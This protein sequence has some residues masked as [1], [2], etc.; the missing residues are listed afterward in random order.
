MVWLRVIRISE[1]AVRL[2]RTVG[3]TRRMWVNRAKKC[4][5]E[6]MS[7]EPIINIAAYRF[8]DLDELPDLRTELRDLCSR[9]SLR[10]TVLIATEGINLF[11]AGTRNSTDQFIAYLRNDP[12]FSRIAIK[13]SAS[14]Y[15]PFNRM[16]VKIKR[17][18]IPFGVPGIDPSK[19]GSP[20]L[21][22]RELKR[23]LDEGRHFTLLDVRNDFE[24]QVGTFQGAVPIGIDHFRDFPAAIQRL[25]EDLKQQPLVMFC[26]GGIRCEKAG[27]Y[28]EQQGYP[29]VFQLEGGILHYLESCGG[30]HYEGDCFVFDQRVA[31]Q[32][33]LLESQTM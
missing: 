29:Q 32:S 27:P 22:P 4:S 14:K 21:S 7:D 28:M 16:L 26:T 3:N 18:I 11:L 8:V 25:P 20:K 9:L 2:T 5:I 6:D 19:K 13:E 12:R 1:F 23:W 15:Q 33:Q 10:G 31:L 30:A 24:V 17:K